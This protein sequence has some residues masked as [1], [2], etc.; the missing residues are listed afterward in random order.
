MNTNS[1]SLGPVHTYPEIFVS[2]IF[3]YAD[4]KISASTRAYTT[5]HTYPIRIRTS[6]KISQQ[7]LIQWRQRIQNYTDT[8]VHTYPDTQ[9]IQKFPLWRAYTEISGY[10]ERIRRTRVDAR[11]IRIKKFCGY[12]NLRIRVDVALLYL[13]VLRLNLFR[14]YFWICDYQ[15]WPPLHFIY[16]T[17]SK[18][19][20]T[21]TGWLPTNL[22]PNQ[23][24]ED[25]VSASHKWALTL[26][27]KSRTWGRP[28]YGLSLLG[29]VR[30]QLCNQGPSSPHPKRV[31][32]N[33]AALGEGP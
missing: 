30:R 9:R 33:K 24:T 14:V 7:V 29:N 22:C 5:V 8:S 2:A 25:P 3:F 16:L 21:K 11:C 23:K 26:F 17:E 15:L 4:T 28:S 13:G 27:K 6:Q 19:K 18:N 20:K 12:K 32:G 10:T 1:F 31:Q